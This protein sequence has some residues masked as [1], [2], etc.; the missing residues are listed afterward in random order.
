MFSLKKHIITLVIAF[1]VVDTI[2]VTLWMSGFNSFDLIFVPTIVISAVIYIRDKGRL[3]DVLK[4]ERK[5][6]FKGNLMFL[7]KYSTWEW[8]I[9][10]LAIKTKDP[11][12]RS[13]ATKLV[14]LNLFTLLMVGNLW[15]M[16]SV[17]N[18]F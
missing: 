6:V 12:F 13:M 7:G 5:N 17:V 11:F 8:N 9:I 10:S 18:N 2:I 14:V 4:K 3:Y 15:M 16:F 1:F